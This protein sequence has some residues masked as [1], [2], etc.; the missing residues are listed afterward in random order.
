MSGEA[1]GSI[2]GDLGAMGR[3][4]EGEDGMGWKRK[5]VVDFAEVV[6][7]NMRLWLYETFCFSLSP[8][9]TTDGKRNSGVRL[10][11]IGLANGPLGVGV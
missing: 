5:V 1:A 3:I 7:G 10:G 11:D 8:E 9:L 4:L 6:V 2:S